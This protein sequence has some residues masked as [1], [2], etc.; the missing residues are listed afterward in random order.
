LP[1]EIISG[2]KISSK[3]KGN[4]FNKQNFPE[5]L[6]VQPYLSKYLLA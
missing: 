4:Y 1:P 5:V 6:T 2:N 3:V